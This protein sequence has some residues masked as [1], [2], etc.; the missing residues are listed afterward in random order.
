VFCNSGPLFHMGT[1]MTTIPTFHM[2]GKNVMVRRVDAEELCRVIQDEGCNGAFLLGPTIAEMTAL[3]SDGRYN[4]KS[5]RAWPGAAPEWAAMTRRDTSRWGRL[6]GGYG[7][8]EVMGLATYKGLGPASVG[9]H[10]KPS[11]LVALRIV[12]SSDEEVPAGEVGE[13]VVR[14]PTVTAGYWNRPS[15]N[16]ERMRGGWWHTNDLGRREADGSLTFIGPKTQ[17]IKSAAENIYPA[18]VEA[19]I[20]SHPAVREAAVIGVPDPKWHQSVKAI[21]VLA[22]GASA[23]EEEIIEWCRSRIASYK[24]PRS[25]E[26]QAEPLPRLGMGKD[27]ATL[28]ARYGGGNYPGAG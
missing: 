25:V 5:L 14:G 9:S 19:C 28:D 11:P 6:A 12:S 27:Y 18:E 15:L 13:I 1:F 24:K 10:G 4:L 7:Q 2:A 23:S 21:V 26:F 3:N 8:T 17:M 20:E 22:D 16:A